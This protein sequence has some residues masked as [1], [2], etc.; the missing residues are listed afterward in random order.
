M[1]RMGFGK[2]PER[3]SL[4]RVVREMPTISRTS[5]GRMKRKQGLLG[6]PKGALVS[7]ERAKKILD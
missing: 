7:K 6:S 2:V 4:Q 5:F 3:Q 1:M